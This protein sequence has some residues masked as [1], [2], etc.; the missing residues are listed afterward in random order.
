MASAEEER[1]RER[2]E[3]SILN[4]RFIIQTDNN[5]ASSNEDIKNQLANKEELRLHIR[6]RRSIKRL[7]EEFGFRA[8]IE[9]Q[10]LDGS[11]KVDVGLTRYET[12][13][14][15]EV[16]VT[17][18]VTHEINKIKRLLKMPYQ[19]ILMLSPKANHLQNIRSRSKEVFSSEQ[20]KRI[21]FYSTDECSEFFL[22]VSG[23][24][25]VEVKRRKGYTISRRYVNQNTLNS[26]SVI[27]RIDNLLEGDD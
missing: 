1:P 7:A 12:N 11:G 10:T 19:K 26:N 16:S 15:C 9:E 13:I 18:S 2:E 3:L 4:T 27:G 8:I 22:E 5:S 21:A 17:T 24:K 6:Y 23:K 25:P 20:F 14:A